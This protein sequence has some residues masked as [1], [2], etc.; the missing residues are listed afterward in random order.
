M[1]EVFKEAIMVLIL[2]EERDKT[3]LSNY[4]PIYL[5]ENI[6]KIQERIINERL[7]DV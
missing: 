1:P 4:R 2:E 6:W 7:Q 5:L 3:N